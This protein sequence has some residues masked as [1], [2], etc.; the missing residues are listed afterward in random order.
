MRPRLSAQE[1]RMK[2]KQRVST[3]RDQKFRVRIYTN[4]PGIFRT[5]DGT[6]YR[7]DSKGQ[8]RRMAAPAP[9]AK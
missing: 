7:C 2:L 3:D 5:R 6:P 9:G 1:A 4:E 8:I